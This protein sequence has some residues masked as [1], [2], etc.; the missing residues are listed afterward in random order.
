MNWSFTIEDYD[1]PSANVLMRQHWS[2]ISKEKR[3]LEA[4]IYSFD[5]PVFP[6]P[7][8]LHI[9]RHIKKGGR[10][11]DPDNLYFSCKN[12]I[13]VLKVRKGRAKVGL[14]V[15]RDDDADTISLS[16]DQ[17]RS[18]DGVG[19]TVVSITDHT[20]TSEDGGLG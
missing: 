9:T 20:L 3:M 15:V 14:G 2:K 18:V 17:I 12:L 13:D 4:I 6:G 1:L 19:R 5:P 7:V 11:F 10:K 16:V 8:E